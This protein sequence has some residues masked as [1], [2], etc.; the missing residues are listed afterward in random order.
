MRSPS[1]LSFVLLFASACSGAVDQSDVIAAQCEEP[2]PVGVTSRRGE[3]LRLDVVQ[4]G[5]KFRQDAGTFGTLGMNL[6]GRCSTNDETTVGCT[7]AP[8]SSR[9]EHVDGERGID[10]AFGQALLQL[11]TLLDEK[12]SEAASGTSYLVL[13]GE[14]RATLHVGSRSGRIVVAIP[15][16]SVRLED[17]RLDGLVTLAAV[18]PPEELRESLRKHVNALSDPPASDLCGSTTLESILEAVDRT[19]DVRLDLVPN[20]AEPCN[21]ISIGMRFRGA[22]ASRVPELPPA[23][24]D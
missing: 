9:G 18:I 1:F 5:E 20:R 23:C 22:P 17:D 10:N 16:T 3:I 7:R 15:L 19:A 12:P 21:G 14:G 2:P 13:E 4:F 11:L 8:G 6:D 24:D